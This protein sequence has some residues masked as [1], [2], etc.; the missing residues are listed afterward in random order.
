M[1]N[2]HW[3]IPNFL[4]LVRSDNFIFIFQRSQE[5]F[6]R[7]GIIV[8]NW[9]PST[10]KE[11]IMIKNN[12]TN[13]MIKNKSNEWIVC[14]SPFFI[15]RRSIQSFGNSRSVVRENICGFIQFC[16]FLDF[17]M[18]SFLWIAGHIQDMY[19]LSVF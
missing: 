9:Q 19:P 10:P 17:M 4:I 12:N 7:Y 2:E 14:V 18:I 11:Q 15:N 6:C 13:K 16:L 8:W 1:K 5:I 3:L